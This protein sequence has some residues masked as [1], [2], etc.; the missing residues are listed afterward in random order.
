M[1]VGQASHAVGVWQAHQS[2][3]SLLQV[4]QQQYMLA[5]LLHPTM[6]SVWSRLLSCLCIR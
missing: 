5:L 4:D 1:S 6:S 2:R 3:P